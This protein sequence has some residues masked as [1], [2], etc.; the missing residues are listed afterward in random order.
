MR[1]AVFL[2][3]DGVINRNLDAHVRTWSELELLPGALDAIR[4]LHDA[5]WLLVVITNQSAIG[6]GY[7]TAE[8]VDDIH[9]R[10][11]EAAGGRLARV[12]HCPHHPDDGCDCRKPKPGMLR[13]AAAA[14]EIDLAASYMVGDH[15]T[16]VEAA[17]AAGVSPIL[18]RSGR[19]KSALSD[20]PK[21]DF[22]VVDDLAAAA[23][24]LLK[25]DRGVSNS[26]DTPTP[27]P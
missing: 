11:N 5:G 12:E 2:D 27:S 8:A 18:V 3:R 13:R 7:T 1:R 14:L 10:L 20:L 9:R 23:R 25:S 26:I 6:R 19:G 24:L 4:D 22:P 17:R 16:D 21:P 15:L